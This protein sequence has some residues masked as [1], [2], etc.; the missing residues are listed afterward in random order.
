MRS[1]DAAV[2][3]S[4]SLG[5]KPKRKR[6]TSARP[7]R[8]SWKLLVKHDQPVPPALQESVRALTN[9]VFEPN[10]SVRLE[11]PTDVLNLITSHGVTHSAARD[12]GETKSRRKATVFASHPIAPPIAHLHD[13]TEEEVWSKPIEDSETQRKIRAWLR[14]FPKEQTD[15]LSTINFLQLKYS[16]ARGLT[17]AWK[18]PQKLRLA[19]AFGS[20]HLLA[21]NGA[22][23]IFQL[24]ELGHGIFLN[25]SNL[26]DEIPAM[27]NPFLYYFESAPTYFE[28]HAS[29]CQTVAQ[30]K[31]QLEALTDENTTLKQATVSSQVLSKLRTSVA[32]GKHNRVAP[33]NMRRLSLD[34][35][36]PGD[37]DSEELVNEL[38]IKEFIDYMS[39][40]DIAHMLLR[41]LDDKTVS[42]TLAALVDAMSEDQRLEFY[43]AYQKC[44][45][46]DELFNFIHKE[47]SAKRFVSRQSSR[48]LGKG[49]ST[50]VRPSEG[51]V[52][53]VRRLLGI[54]DI[55]PPL[56]L[57]ETG[58]T[59]DEEQVLG[60][61]SSIV[62][63]CAKLRN[64]IDNFSLEEIIP[65]NSTVREAIQKLLVIQGSRGNN[66]KTELDPPEEP[67]PDEDTATV[68]NEREDDENEEEEEDEFD[69]L[70]DSDN[71][72]KKRATSARRKPRKRRA[73]VAGKSKARTMPLA[74]VCSSI[75]SLMCE[76]LWQETNDRAKL[77]LRT[78]MRQYFIRVYGLK[79]LAMAHIASFKHSLG[80]HQKE[81]TRVGLFY[82][83][84]G[85]DE[86]RKLSSDYAFEFF[87]IVTKHILAVHTKAP[88]KPFLAPTDALDSL[89]SIV[90]AWNDWMGDGYA[91][92]EAKKRSIV[93]PKAIEVTRLSFEGNGRE[94]KVVAF[95][96]SLR[97]K[98][99]IP[100][101]EF[102]SGI[103]ACWQE[104]F[105]TTVQLIR[106]KFR[107]ADKN[108][109]GTM[110]FEEFFAF[111]QSSNVLLGED[112]TSK[113]SSVATI[114]RKT[115]PK[116]TPTSES[117]IKR[118][119]ALNEA[120]Q[121][122]DALGIYDSLTNDDNIIDENV[123]IEY[124]LTQVRWL[125]HEETSGV[126]AK[127]PE[128]ACPDEELATPPCSTN[129]QACSP[130]MG[131]NGH[132]PLQPASEVNA[133]LTEE[134]PSQPVEEIDLQPDEANVQLTGETNLQLTDDSNI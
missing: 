5:T 22:S 33:N 32:F 14:E 18:D 105:E 10:E 79:S 16:Q 124:M 66:A 29:T 67:K 24:Q 50:S 127:Q 93:L 44:M 110:D 65:I 69:V 54:D 88:V 2:Q 81:N 86:N 17:S 63:I 130:L 42:L 39:P 94:A 15:F 40:D 115:I 134:T 37:T 129:E 46:G 116:K 118:L 38:Q 6:A 99:Q 80:V 120:R 7:T 90:Y 25:Y 72:T 73:A 27:M 131:C 53:Q 76:K 20:L 43:A 97:D 77:A 9:Q 98:Q 11:L 113:R 56:P 112:T 108:G 48:F 132:S 92:V 104:L 75:S 58:F 31:R 122:R 96:D 82:W 36:N 133:P 126:E 51:F 34:G 23:S 91:T 95:V 30:L 57:K 8:F 45:S 84:L 128:D 21:S 119:A 117:E 62:Q 59:A 100:M 49:M 68:P 78:F 26:R 114:F 85:C 74:D 19:V 107:Q 41:I 47:V 102:L 52:L 28:R 109:D 4:S 12:E 89:E 64:E 123:F 87:I 111:L 83:F 101:E 35:Q 103:M 60:T 3:A 71:S 70:D 13:E 125:S 55:P 1:P 106:A 121:R 61:I